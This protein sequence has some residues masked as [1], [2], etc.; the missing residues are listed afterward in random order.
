[1]K[2]YVVVSICQNLVD[3]VQGFSDLG[4]AETELA[5]ER[6]RLGI[7]PNQEE[8]ENDVQLHEIEV[9]TRP[10]SVLNRLTW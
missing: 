6:K 10:V 9:D 4:L 2:I 3:L 5:S 7:T 1:M 8:S